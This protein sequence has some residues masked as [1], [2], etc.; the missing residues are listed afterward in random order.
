MRYFVTVEGH[1][2][3]VEIDGDDVFVDGVPVE[4]ELVDRAGT[5]S[6]SLILDGRS[7]RIHARRAG[8]EIWTVHHDGQPYRV[9]VIEERAQRAREMTLSEEGVMA[10]QTVRAPMPGL[11]LRVEVEAGDDVASG[12]GLM[13]VEAMKMENELRAQSAGRVG[14]IHV[15]AGQTVEKDDVLIEFERVDAAPA[16]TP[17][18]SGS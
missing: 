18:G 7:H 12:Q 8:A 11:V 6:S 17:E 4:A 15:Q 1:Q 10:P 16:S 5:P 14:R 9:E 13:I 2:V 3:E